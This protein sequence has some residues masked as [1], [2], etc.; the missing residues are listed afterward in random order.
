MSGA[1]NL[2][3][4]WSSRD[5]DVARNLVCMYGGNALPKG[6]WESVTLIVWG[7]SQLL[8][9]GDEALQQEIAALQDRGVT[10]MACRSCAE[11]YDMVETME[12]LHL[13]VEYVGAFFTTVLKDDS[14]RSVTF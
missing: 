4:V 2:C 6:W 8:L 1:Q 13:D 10:V 7:P 9:A 14:W 3:I 11:R 5:P 12:A